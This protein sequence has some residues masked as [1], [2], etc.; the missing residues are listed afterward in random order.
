MEYEKNKVKTTEK[1]KQLKKSTLNFD[2]QI[3]ELAEQKEM[4]KIKYENIIM[5][6]DN[7]KN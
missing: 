2:K 7:Y 1:L 6:I 5:Q 4:Y 3:D